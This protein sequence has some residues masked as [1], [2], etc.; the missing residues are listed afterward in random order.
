MSTLIIGTG[1][2]GTALADSYRA[3]GLATVQT[4]RHVGRADLSIGN[5]AALDRLLGESVFDQVVVVGQLT[6]PAIDWVLERVD[7]PRW[8]V[9]SSQQLASPVLAPRSATARAREA[10]VL[11]RGACVLRP[12]MIFGR[13]RDA[14]V[15]RVIRFMNRSRLALVPGPG[16][17]EMQPLHVDD[18]VAL[19]HCHK[20]AA[21]GGL[22]PVACS[23][24]IPII[25][26]VDTIGQILG[27]RL[28]PVVIPSA[29]VAIA[30]RVA[31]LLRLRPDQISRLTQQKVV[32]ATSTEAA[33]DWSP[34]PLG[35][36]VEQ[37]VGEA[38]LDA[39]R[40]T[41]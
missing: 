27:L 30:A 41:G 14:N 19:I 4:S 15:S 40:R 13:G 31:P 11:S 28:P 5:G 8:L 9:L 18:L 20:K 22:H 36:R 7:G 23:E 3:M 1:F 12:T 34:A 33:F 32:D 39:P 6:G 24:A 25:E 17:Q 21:S 29:V 16:D 2:V 10:L 37:A 26:L 38:I 35:L